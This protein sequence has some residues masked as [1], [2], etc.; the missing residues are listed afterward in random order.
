[1]Q[2]PSRCMIARHLQTAYHHYLFTNTPLFPTTLHQTQHYHTHM[3][4]TDSLPHTS[5]FSALLP[6]YTKTHYFELGIITPYGCRRTRYQDTE[7]APLQHWAL[8][9]HTNPS[10][11]YPRTS[12]ASFWL[13]WTT[14]LSAELNTDDPDLTPTPCLV[15]LYCTASSY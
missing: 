6:L 5:T 13:Y 9:C 10:F 14:A 3:T 11:P 8:E 1:M 7:T 2:D 12:T 15:G 4:P